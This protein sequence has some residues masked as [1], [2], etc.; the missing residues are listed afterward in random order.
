MYL[1]YNKGPTSSGKTSMIGH[2]AKITGHRMVRIN[3]HEHTDIQEYL[4]TYITNE[5]GKLVWNQ[6]VLV[7]ALQKV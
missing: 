7:E 5:K 1:F 3:N 4:G 6:G 2:L